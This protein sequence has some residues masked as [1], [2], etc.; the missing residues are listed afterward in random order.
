M[1]DPRERSL[2]TSFFAALFVACLLLCG[3]ASA[4]P[5]ITLSKK[6]GPPTARILVSGRGFDPNVGV[7]IFFDTKDRALVI[8]NRKGEFHDAGIYAP[9]SAPPG[10]H[11][12]TALERTNHK[13]AQQPFL[14][15]TNWSQFHFAPNHEG[16]NPYENVLNPST[17]RNL[18][19]KWRFGTGLRV[20]SSPAVADG[21]LYVGSEDHFLYA[22]NA[23]T[24]A[25]LWSY[26]TGGYQYSSPAVMDGVVYFCS[27][28]GGDAVYALNAST[29]VPLW[30]HSMT[31]PLDPTVANGVVYITSGYNSITVSALNASTGAVLWNSSVGDTVGSDP[32]VANGVVYVGSGYNVYALDASTGAER[33]RY[34]TG[35]YVES[36]PVVANGVVYVGSDDGNVYALDASGGFKLW[37]YT[38]GNRVYSS[39]AAASG[40]V[41]VGSDDGNVYALNAYSGAKLW[42]YTTGI[43]RVDSS[44][45]VANGVVYVGSYD[46]NV[47]AL[48]GST[49]ALLWRYSTGDSVDSSPT[50]ANG[51]IYVG[52]RDFNVYA[53]GLPNEE[54][55]KRDR[56]GS[57][58]ASNRPDL[59]MLRPKYNLKVNDN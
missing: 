28:N 48:N 25:K 11:W 57:R 17:V 10:D 36:S 15:Q 32:A 23:S 59:K 19:L 18:D 6:S 38:T 31:Y 41:Y 58:A 1:F 14:I 54:R 26:G 8:T 49:G 22:L 52:S 35:N 37:N 4:A 16:L 7:D 13:G 5:S 20:F 39:P 27:Y 44:P 9:R 53:F 3:T 47:Y 40:V 56:A 51:M 46:D 24:G 45:A 2:A 34:T 30:S 55:A 43:F 33:W 12:V 42:S 21:V 50:V 29:G